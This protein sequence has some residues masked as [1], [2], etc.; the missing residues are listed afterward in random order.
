MV[1]SGGYGYSPVLHYSSVPS[2]VGPYHIR[3]LPPGGFWCDCI[4]VGCISSEPQERGRGLWTRTFS[5]RRDRYG[6]DKVFARIDEWKTEQYKGKGKEIKRFKTDDC[7]FTVTGMKAQILINRLGPAGV[8][9]RPP[10]QA[11]QDTPPLR[12]L[13]F[14]AAADA[15]DAAAAAAAAGFRKR[16]QEC[17]SEVKLRKVWR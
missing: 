13:S 15:D 9:V 17:R 6:D 8:G 16:K 10:P 1:L 11:A 7:S 14:H 4:T 2:S 5:I 3:K 12:L